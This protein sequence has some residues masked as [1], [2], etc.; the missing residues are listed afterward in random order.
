MP[1]NEESTNTSFAARKA[2]RE[3]QEAAGETPEPTRKQG[4]FRAGLD[5]ENPLLLVT[6]VQ[7]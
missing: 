6:H 3:A 5:A 1:K 4:G 7:A 2:E